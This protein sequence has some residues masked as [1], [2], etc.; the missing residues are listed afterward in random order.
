MLN[1]AQEGVQGGTLAGGSPFYLFLHFVRVRR[2]AGRRIVPHAAR[3]T[4]FLC[5]CAK[6]RGGAPKKRAFGGGRKLITTVTPASSTT[7]A[8][9]PSPV[10]F[11]PGEGKHSDNHQAPHKSG[12]DG[13]RPPRQERSREWWS[14]RGKK[15]AFLWRLDTVSLGKHQGN[16]VERQDRAA[17][18]TQRNGAHAQR[19]KF[20][21][22]P[23]RGFP[24]G[25][26]SCA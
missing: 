17:N 18:T 22:N 4:P 9:R 1:E 3:S 2:Y 13:S 26:S 19:Q 10:T 12:E 16:G 14:R 7:R 25:P 20:R 5:S 8:K 6:K 15:G 21:G 11:A 23:R 24:L